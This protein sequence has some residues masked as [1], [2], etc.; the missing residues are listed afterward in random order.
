MTQ[1]IN[2]D[3]TKPFAQGDVMW[4][5]VS[6][7]PEDVV[8]QSA[9]NGNY[10]VAHSETGHNHVM[11]A[12]TTDFYMASNDEFVGFVDV[13]ETTNLVHLRGFDT[14]KTIGVPP[15]KYRIVRQ[16]E[17]TADGYRRAAD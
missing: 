9:E 1:S 5:P 16:R 2:I 6:T 12:N 10:V 4:F 13:K 11:D 15:G 3:P 7:I 14:H 17:Y 8:V